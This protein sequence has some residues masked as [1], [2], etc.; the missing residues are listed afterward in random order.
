[1]R[2]L[3]INQPGQ[4]SLKTKDRPWGPGEEANVLKDGAESF[5]QVSGR[6]ELRAR[7]QS[8]SGRA[9]NPLNTRLAWLAR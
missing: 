6:V 7:C 3:V 5:G 4:Q 9:V 2:F 8:V 1:M